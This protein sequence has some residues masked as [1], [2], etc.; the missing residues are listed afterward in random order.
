MQCRPE[1]IKKGFDKARITAA[2]SMDYLM[3]ENP[4]DDDD[5]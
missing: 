3:T 2:L 1:L 5:M 4:F